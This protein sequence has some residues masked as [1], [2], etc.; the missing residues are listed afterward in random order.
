MHPSRRLPSGRTEGQPLAVREALAAGL[1]VVAS[2]A[3]GIEELATTEG[4]R[5]QLGCR[6]TIRPPSPAGSHRY[7]SE[8]GV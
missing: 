4:P 1:P 3:G 6:P 5:L 2:A 8:T 7:V